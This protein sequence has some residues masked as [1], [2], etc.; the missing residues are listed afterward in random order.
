MDRV[1]P[2][3]T[4]GFKKLMIVDAHSGSINFKKNRFNPDRESVVQKKVKK[5]A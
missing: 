4:P 2:P 3:A 5:S 1:F